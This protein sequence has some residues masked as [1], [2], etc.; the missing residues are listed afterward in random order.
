M[1][2]NYSL[3]VAPTVHILFLFFVINQF[4]NFKCFC[5][6]P[7]YPL[8]Y[9]LMCACANPLHAFCEAI[10]QLGIYTGE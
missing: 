6:L 1:N 9:M 4:N 7:G 10:P 8:I 5:F 2:H 3:A